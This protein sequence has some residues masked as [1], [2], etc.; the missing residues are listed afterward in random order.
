MLPVCLPFYYQSHNEKGNGG[1]PEILPFDVHF[2][3][4]LKMYCQ[5][6]TSELK[7]FCT[8][9]INWDL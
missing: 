5:R 3:E 6:T 1:F 9:Y 8:G 7:K 4:E 2:N